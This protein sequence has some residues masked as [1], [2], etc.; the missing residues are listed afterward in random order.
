MVN[1]GGIRAVVVA[2][3]LVA[4]GLALTPSVSA[5]DPDCTF[6]LHEGTFQVHYECDPWKKD[7]SECFLTIKV[8]FVHQRVFCE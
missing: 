3:I 4:T 8:L 7:E 2:S 6:T 5:H 1:P